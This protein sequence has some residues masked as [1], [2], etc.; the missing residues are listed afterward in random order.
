MLFQCQLSCNNFPNTIWG[1]G[2]TRHGHV[3]PAQIPALIANHI[4][5]HRNLKQSGRKIRQNCIL[6]TVLVCYMIVTSIVDSHMK[7]YIK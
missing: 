3:H 1:P 7:K 4:A 6:Y 5:F 2:H